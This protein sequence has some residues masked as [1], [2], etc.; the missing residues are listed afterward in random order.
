MF[1][2]KKLR[3]AF[4]LGVVVILFVVTLIILIP[5][6][7]YTNSTT[8]VMS[9]FGAVAIAFLPILIIGR[10]A[11]DKVIG[12]PLA[13]LQIAVQKI[14]EGNFDVEFDTKRTDEIGELARSLNT[15]RSEIN[16]VIDDINGNAVAIAKG[17]LIKIDPSNI[18]KSKGQYQKLL[19]IVEE[20]AQSVEAY[21]DALELG[22]IIFDTNFKIQ[23]INKYKRNLG[24]DFFKMYEKTLAQVMPKEEADLH[25]SKLTEAASTGKTVSYEVDVKL[26]NGKMSYFNHSMLVIKDYN[27]KVLSYLNVATDVTDMVTAKVLSDKIRVYQANE[28]TAVASELANSL[29]Q[30]L[31]K[32]DY[33]PSPPDRDT[34]ESAG[35]YQ[36]IADTMK[37][38]LG[39][40]EGYINEIRTSLASMADGNLTIRINNDYIGEFSTIKTSINNIGSSLQRTMNDIAVASE[41]VLQGASRMS[42]SA[43]ELSQGAKS[44]ASSVESL[45]H[46]LDDIGLKIAENAGNVATAHDLSDKSTS[47]AKDGNDAMAQMV[48]A[49]GKIKESSSSIS[50]IVKII[51]DIAFQTN[52]LAL[53]ASVEAARAGEHGKGFS[54]VADEVRTLAGRSQ[55]AATETTGLIEDSINRVDVGSSIATTTAVSLADIVV[56]ASE[57]LG[58]LNKISESSNQQLKAIVHVSEGIGMVERVV[59]SN[60][61]VS[62]ETAQTSEELNTQA[63]LLKNLVSFFKLK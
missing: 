16:L 28:A 54:V 29:G 1:G 46:T 24:F 30:G 58:V 32:F 3:S 11:V 45:H 35:Y 44:Q 4:S 37:N 15:M 33:T 25:A 17:D 20:V 23:F 10:I 19:D 18:L 38:S 13:N 40:I 22:I 51:Q 14:A 55:T 2:F 49:M 7:I 57:V 43:E 52:L 36:Q 42:L 48:D 31:L 62:K 63:E 60:L 8:L 27:G 26:S 9:I 41:Q 47:T 5:V 59:S 12:K 21:F 56:S 34:E 6:Y 53:N 61:R 50:Q 39:F